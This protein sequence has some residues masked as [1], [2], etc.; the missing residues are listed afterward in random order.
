MGHDLHS[1]ARR[2]HW[3]TCNALNRDSEDSAGRGIGGMLSA[4]R[5]TGGDLR[6]DT[7]CIAVA[8]GRGQK[9]M[10]RRKRTR[11]CAR[12]WKSGNP[13]GWRYQRTVLAASPRHL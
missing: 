6:A 1:S 8:E 9:D 2:L 7:E 5:R 4:G 13:G 11:W 3:E 12:L 10:V